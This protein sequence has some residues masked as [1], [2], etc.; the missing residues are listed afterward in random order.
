[1]LLYCTGWGFPLTVNFVDLFIVL[2][3]GVLPAILNSL[4][5]HYCSTYKATIQMISLRHLSHNRINV[6]IIISR[7][8][9]IVALFARIYVT[10]VT[11]YCSLALYENIQIRHSR[12]HIRHSRSH[13]YPVVINGKQFHSLYRLAL[14]TVYLFNW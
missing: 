1:M 8:I 13:I 9:Q 5:S 14:N 2:C 3:Y 11:T 7:T 10:P 4:Y 12:S 6:F